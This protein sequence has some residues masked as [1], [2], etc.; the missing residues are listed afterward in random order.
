MSLS[1][2]RKSLALPPLMAALLALGACSAG[3]PSAPP[4]PA[5]EKA[6]PLTTADADFVQKLNEMDM[7]QIA[8]AKIAETHAA[9]SDV[10]TLGATIVKDLTGNQDRLTKLVTT[11]AI[12]LTA[13]PSSEDQKIIDRMQHVHGAA[14][15]RNYIRYLSR[16]HAKMKPVIESEIASSKNPD[17]VKL[18]ND[19][20]AMLAAYEAQ[21]K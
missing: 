17:L 19:T 12:T 15:D 3:Q 5:V 10:A 2:R 1:S 18:A 21:L 6:A 4:L 13:K 7:T 9:R 14:F 16:D 11:H 8:L 20:K